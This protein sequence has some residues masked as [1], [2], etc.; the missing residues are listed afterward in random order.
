M[1]VRVICNVCKKSTKGDSD[2]VDCVLCN[3]PFHAVTCIGLSRSTLKSMTDSPNLKWFC[4]RCI[5]TSFTTMNMI[6]KKFDESREFVDKKLEEISDA[7]KKP[8]YYTE[9]MEKISFLSTEVASLKT[10]IETPSNSV[11]RARNGSL[12]L[13]IP[14]TS[15]Y[16]Q[17]TA[18]ENDTEDNN[19]P[20]RSRRAFTPRVVINGTDEEDMG[21]S[22]VRFIEKPTW[23]HVS[24]FEPN[25]DVDKVTAWF[26]DKLNS[27]EIQCVKLIPRNRQIEDL[28]FVS[29]KLGV[30]ASVVS[31]VMDPKTW[32]RIVQVRPFQQRSGSPRTFRF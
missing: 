12:R 24:Q 26:K 27:T 2:I 16:S 10:S 6:S 25:V 8:D 5:G 4:D 20:K 31:T 32:P 1:S 3:N 19:E 23:F 29:F 11:K 18:T 21:T 28:A 17:I 7:I 15:S 22:E 30:P 14:G 9:M 13:N